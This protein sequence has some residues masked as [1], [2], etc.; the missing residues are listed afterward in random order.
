MKTSLKVLCALMVC[1]LL[2]A[3]CSSTRNA[4]NGTVNV[5][6]GKFTGTWTVT[7]VNYENLVEGSVQ[8]VFDQA[9]PAAFINS[10]WQLTNSGNGMYTLSNGTSQSIYWSVNN[11]DPSGQMFQFKKIYQGDKPKN[12]AEGYQLYVASNDGNTMVL[13]TPVSLGTG[14]GYVVYTFAKK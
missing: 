4:A 2:F 9:P 10:T 3:N 7:N 1:T 6:R 14:T 5:S 8:S 12:V 11:N 13:K